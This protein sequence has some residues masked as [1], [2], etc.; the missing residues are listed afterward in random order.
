MEE[1]TA[2]VHLGTVRTFDPD[3]GWGVVD[4]A[5]TPGGCWVHYSVLM[6]S[7]FRR[8]TPGQNVSFRAEAARLDGFAFRATKI[9]TG[10]IEPADAL[11]EIPGR[12]ALGSAPSRQ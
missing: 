5:D 12:L 7:G 11:P 4:A 8:L 10:G 6:S 3:T 2:M 9:W 1:F